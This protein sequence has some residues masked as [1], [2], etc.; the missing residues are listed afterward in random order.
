MSGTTRLV[1]GMISTRSKKK[2]VREMRIDMDRVTFTQP[3]LP[4]WDGAGEGK[5]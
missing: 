4:A 1:D 5:G 2:T 3:H